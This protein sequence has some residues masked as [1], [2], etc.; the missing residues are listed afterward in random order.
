MMVGCVWDGARQVKLGEDMLADISRA[1]F[2]DGIKSLDLL[3]SLELLVAWYAQPA[4][5]W[6]VG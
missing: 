4:C 1:V 2:V 6:D 3:Q 5:G